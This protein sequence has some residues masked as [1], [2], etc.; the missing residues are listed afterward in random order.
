MVV[1]GLMMNYEVDDYMYFI[2]ILMLKG[3]RILERR[4]G[5][6]VRLSMGME[7]CVLLFLMCVPVLPSVPVHLPAILTH[8]SITVSCEIIPLKHQR[9]LHL[10]RSSKAQ[11][12]AFSFSDYGSILGYSVD[13]YRG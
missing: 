12:T 5:C 6:L 11:A 3:I 8:D 9:C 7:L 4:L 1:C 10:Q 13:S 2:V